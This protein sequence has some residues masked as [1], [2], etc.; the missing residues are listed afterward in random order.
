M[1]GEG[2]V[3]KYKEMGGKQLMSWSVENGKIAMWIE[4]WMDIWFNVYKDQMDE[5]DGKSMG[6]Y[7]FQLWDGQMG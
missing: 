1:S 2:Q 4:G 7:D 3:M 5:N 6:G